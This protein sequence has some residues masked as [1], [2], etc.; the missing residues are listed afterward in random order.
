M[1]VTRVSQQ[2]INDELI[3]RFIGDIERIEAILRGQ[4]THF[5]DILRALLA[6]LVPMFPQYSKVY[7]VIAV[8]PTQ[9]VRNDTQSLMPIRV[10]NEDAALFLYLGQ[11]DIIVPAGERIDPG[12]TSTF[13]LRKGQDVW[14]VANAGALQVIVSVP[15]SAYTAVIFDGPIIM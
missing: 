3:R 14:G 11:R 13:V 9:L 7:N 4:T 6:S 10:R 5:D 1:G 8:T 15:E 12:Q 2:Q